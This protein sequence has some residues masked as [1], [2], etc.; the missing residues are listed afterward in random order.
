M[1]K[2]LK[3]YSRIKYVKRKPNLR[4]LKKEESPFV[5]YERN[6]FPGNLAEMATTRRSL[7]S[8]IK[9]KTLPQITQ[10]KIEEIRQASLPKEYKNYL[11][12]KKYEQKKRYLKE[13]TS[14]NPLT[15]AIYQIRAMTEQSKRRISSNLEFSLPPESRFKN[16]LIM[17][18]Y[19]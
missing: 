15:T 8:L 12:E 5:R 17:K 2:H 1:T 18:S 16:Y 11:E 6:Q 7:I 3:S 10:D 14:R 13:M 4:S 9:Q 19:S